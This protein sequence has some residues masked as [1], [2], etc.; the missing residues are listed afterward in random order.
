MNHSCQNGYGVTA[1]EISRYDWEARLEGASHKECRFYW[2]VLSDAAAKCGVAGDDVG[3]RVYTFLAAVSSFLANFDARGNPYVAMGTW[4]DGSHSL[5]AEDLLV[6]DVL[7][8]RGIVES[9]V[10]PEFRAR[11]ADVLWT[12]K[13]DVKAARTAVTAFIESALRLKSDGLI[14]PHNERLRRAAQIC[15]NKGF[16]TERSTVLSAIESAID[17]FHNEEKPD[18]VCHGLMTILLEVRQGDPVKYSALSERIANDRAKKGE[19]Y[20][21]EMYWLLAAQ[22]HHKAKREDDVPRCQLAAAECSISR[23]EDELKK[24]GSMSAAHWYGRGVEALRRAKADPERIKT[25]HRRFLELQKMGLKEMKP[26]D[27]GLWYD[28]EFQKHEKETQERASAFVQGL[29]FQTAM[30]RFVHVTLPIDFE[31]LK[32][33]YVEASKGMIAGKLFGS[34]VL[35]HTG[36]VADSIPP[37]SLS[38]DEVDVESL[39]KRLCQQAASV[40]WPVRVI[41]MIEPARMT[42]LDE[43]PVSLKALLYLVVNNPFIPQSHEGIYLRGIQAGFLGDWLVAMHLLVPQ[44]EASIRLVLQQRG[45]VTSTLVDGIQQERDL[46]QLLWLPDV[47][48]IFGVNVLFDLRGIL[49]E[50]FGY[51]LRNQLA[52][53]LLPEGGFYREASA[54]LWWLVLRLCWKG[55]RM[56]HLSDDE[57]GKA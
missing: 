17:E 48:K 24:Q 37:E 8:L 13:K 44:I 6:P 38:S 2:S 45:V 49:I 33:T 12:T 36:K 23:G 18:H 19:W 52:H 26:L 47:E 50:R 39:R 54:Y 27:I 28:P 21:C 25:A 34:F 40:D 32:K 51:N 56:V 1:E 5:C 41:W 55:F 7:A 16:E 30:E 4:V 29:D 31:V 3:Q 43:H 11:V 35:D 10:D 9:I 42:I 14:I 20:L 53:G 46:N 22:W 57:I 15:A